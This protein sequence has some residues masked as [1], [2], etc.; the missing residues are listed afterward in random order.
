MPTAQESWRQARRELES[1]LKEQPEND[2]L[3][4]DLALTNMG[5]GDKAAAL[6]L[7]ERT[8]AVNPIEKDAMNGPFSIEILARVAVGMGEPDRAIAALQ[9]IL[10]IPYGGALV[11]ACRLLLHYF[12]SIRCSIRFAMIRASKN[13]P[14]RPRRKNRKAQ[15]RCSTKASRARHNMKYWESSPII[16][17]RPD[18]VGAVSQRLIPTGERS[19]LQTHIAATES[20]SLC[21]RMKS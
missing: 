20:V 6:A 15:P 9:K 16:S 18:G 1:F 7:T 21:A 19:G 2:G 8:I 4:G 17:A 10:S 14:P 12:G 13:S 5:L 11:G 3:M